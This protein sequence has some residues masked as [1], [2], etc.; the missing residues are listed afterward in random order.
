MQSESEN[1]ANVKAKFDFKNIEI[2]QNK[3]YAK[4][5][6]YLGRKNRAVVEKLVLILKYSYVRNLLFKN[7]VFHGKF[8]GLTRKFY[9][10]ICA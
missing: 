6:R 4:K 10:E 1:L 2:L 9:R 5:K 7:L 8:Y 3:I